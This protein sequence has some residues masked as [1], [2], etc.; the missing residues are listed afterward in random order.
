MAASVRA[1]VLAQAGGRSWIVVDGRLPK[2]AA[3]CL[4]DLLRG[5]CGR[6]SVVFLDL[7]EAQLPV[8]EQVR[9]AFLPEG[10]RSFHIMADDPLRSFLA[11]DRRVTAHSSVAQAWSAWSSA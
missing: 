5:R 6:A 10:P 3:P 2:P 1:R 4:C 7:R 9:G 8:G 11:T